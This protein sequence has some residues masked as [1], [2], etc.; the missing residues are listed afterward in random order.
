MSGNRLVDYL[1]H[2]AQAAQQACNYVEGMDRR[3]FLADRRTQQ[4]TI[5]NIIVI[6]EV[7][8]RLLQG[9]VAFVERHPQIPWRSMKGM[10]NRIAHG[11]FDINL[12]VV[13]ETVQTALPELLGQISA[14]RADAAT[15][16][17]DDS[18]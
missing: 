13:W 3:T 1:D 2:I 7:A 14:I 16:P 5:L 11:Y 9:H 17:D 12:D 18:K 6:G 8:T 4:A 15:W 10:R